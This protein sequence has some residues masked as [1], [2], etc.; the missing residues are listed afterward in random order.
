[1]KLKIEKIAIF[2]EFPNDGG[3]Q[4]LR[5]LIF[6]DDAFFAFKSVL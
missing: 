5:K 1:M 6:N 4:A 2:H 3:K